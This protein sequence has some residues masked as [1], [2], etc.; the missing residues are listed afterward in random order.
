M[1]MKY[2]NLYVDEKY[3]SIVEPNLYANTT[4]QPGVT[5]NDK[6]QVDA[7][8]GKIYIYKTV[9]DGNGDPQTPAGDFESTGAENILI[10]I[11]LNNA[12][13]KSKKIYGVQANTVAYNLGEEVLSTLVQ[14]NRDDIQ[15]SGY[16]CLAYEG[17]DAEDLG[18]TTVENI[19][20]KI[21][22]AR[23]V[24]RKKHA[25]PGIV[26]ASVDTY[27]AMLEIAGEKYIPVTNE[28]MWTNGR[29]GKY[30]GMTWYECDGMAGTA[31]YYDDAGTLRT[32]ALDNVE[33]IMYDFNAFHVVNNLNALRIIN[34]EDFIGSKAQNEINCGYKVSNADCVYVKS[35][36]PLSA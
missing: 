7:N 12:F 36:A 20:A 21:L 17:T 29:V 8:S 9:K 22:G 26:L 3:S 23:K 25:T 13:R 28:D 19:K 4:M 35:K 6:H 32:V 15:R 16:A 10:P 30:L 27:S 2:N 1:S 14:E 5:Y 18:A 24:M 33:F 31:K 11:T 34:S